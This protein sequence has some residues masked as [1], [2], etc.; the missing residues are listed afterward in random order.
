[1][2]IRTTDQKERKRYYTKSGKLRPY[3]FSV[4][5]IETQ[6][7][8]ND[9]ITLSMPSSSTGLYEVRW[10][11]NG[12]WQEWNSFETLTEARKQVAVFKALAGHKKWNSG[13]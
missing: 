6:W 5:M 2:T 1:M 10:Y 11:S 7:A 12:K 3:A 9:E 4:G 8:G 13:T